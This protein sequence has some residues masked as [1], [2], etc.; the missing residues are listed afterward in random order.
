[1]NLSSLHLE[2]FEQYL[3]RLLAA[4]PVALLVIL[5]ALA[6]SFVVNRAL[7]LLSNKTSLSHEN[8]APFRKIMRV[9]IAIAALVLILNVFGFSLGGL[10]TILSTV[11]AMVAIGFVAVWSVLSNT[12]CTFIILLSRPFAIGDEVGFAGEDVKGRVEDMNFIYTTLRCDDGSLLQIPNN[13]FFQRVVRRRPSSAPV[14]LETQ[15]NRPALQRTPAPSPA[16]G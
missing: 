15:L 8:V 10:W 14:S 7:T 3:P 16:R 6:L 11:L 1:M 13:L 5:G 12:L 2:H 9:L 4:L